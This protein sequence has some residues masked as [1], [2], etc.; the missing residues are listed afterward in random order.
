MRASDAPVFFRVKLESGRRQAASGG[1]DGSEVPGL[2]LALAEWEAEDFACRAFDR[3]V[4]ALAGTA[5]G[6]DFEIR[7]SGEAGR[8]EAAAGQVALRCQRLADRRNTAS[9]CELFVRVLGAH[10]GL[11]DGA[12]PQA[13]ASLA[14]ALDTWQWVLRLDPEASLAVQVAAL[15]HRPAPPARAA[16]VPSAAASPTFPEDGSRR[17]ALATDELLADLGIDLVTRVRAY[18]LIA[19]LQRPP[20]TMAGRPPVATAEQALLD[21]ADAL[22]FL[23]LDSADYLAEHGV[24]PAARQIAGLLARLRPASRTRIRGMRLRAEI[25]RMILAAEGDRERRARVQHGR[26]APDST[27]Q[28]APVRGAKPSRAVV[29]ARSRLSAGLA[30]AAGIARTRTVALLARAAALG[31]L[32]G[33]AA[34]RSSVPVRS[35]SGAHG[36]GL[37]HS[38]AAAGSHPGARPGAL[39]PASHATVS[40]QAGLA[41]A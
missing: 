10:R 27:V 23:S 13:A 6:G 39:E 26:P 35:G 19:R 32:A 30:G 25:A 41:K 40:R 3:R 8:L 2:D 14:R 33:P 5:R 28:A 34:N 21:D 7:L 12:D 15:F 29:M 37:D 9:D 1:S 16:G 18:R 38:N 17:G 11:Y 22:S 24:E 20:A 36:A 4:E 31:A